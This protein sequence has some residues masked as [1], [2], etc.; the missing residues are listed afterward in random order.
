M[1]STV[2]DLSLDSNYISTYKTVERIGHMISEFEIRIKYIS[3]QVDNIEKSILDHSAL[4]TSSAIYGGLLVY[5][6]T[7]NLNLTLSQLR[8]LL[9]ARIL[10]NVRAVE[11]LKY[12][13]QVL[14]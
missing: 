10:A 14:A 13:L 2:S 1:K 8:L 6:S 3:K 12:N 9:A 7:I 11:V 4:I 5:T